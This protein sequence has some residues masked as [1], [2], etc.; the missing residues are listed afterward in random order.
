MT[1]GTLIGSTLSFNANSS[2]VTLTYGIVD[3]SIVEGPET[4]TFSVGPGRATS[5]ERG[6]ATATI[7]DN[8][9]VPSAIR[10]SR[11]FERRRGW[12]TRHDHV[13]PNRQPAAGLTVKHQRPHGSGPGRRPR[14][15][16]GDGWNVRR[17]HGWVTF[18]IG[19]STVVVTFGVVDDSIVEAAETL[20][21][22]VLSD[23]LR[24][25]FAV[26][27]QCDGHRQR[28]PPVGDGGRDERWR[29]RGTGRHHLHSDGGHGRHSVSTRFVEDRLRTPASGGRRGCTSRGGRHLQLD[30]RRRDL[31]CRLGGGDADL[32]RSSTTRR[33]KDPRRSGSPFNPAAPMPS[34]RRARPPPRSLTT[35]SPATPE[36]Q[37]DRRPT[38]SEGGGPVV[39]TFTRTGSTGAALSIAGSTA[40]TTVAGST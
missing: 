34:V 11:R 20:G 21:F 29:G 28:R 15:A 5:S 39:V 24:T 25:R 16:L 32:L 2:T 35:T 6:D 22:N 4:L 18:N 26:G 27:G 13:H 40:G 7:V 23:P 1:G 33:S 37:C 17:G 3:D 31:R 10:H 12:L 14:T 19:V 30:V 9:S 38:Q 36:H 8:D